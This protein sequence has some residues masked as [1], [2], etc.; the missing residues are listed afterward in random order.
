MSTRTPRPCDIKA[1]EAEIDRLKRTDMNPPRTYTFACKPFDSR[2]YYPIVGSKGHEIKSVGFS[3]AKIRAVQILATRPLIEIVAIK[4]GG[5]PR[6]QFTREMLPSQMKSL[7]V[8]TML[9]A[10]QGRLV[11]IHQK[12]EKKT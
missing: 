4:Y 12:R 8:Q 1:L 9:D 3:M 11:S 5:K 10:Q 2:E 7:M 6:K